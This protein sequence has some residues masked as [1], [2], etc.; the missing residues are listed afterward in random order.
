M[1]LMLHIHN[2]VQVNVD[3]KSLQMNECPEHGVV[4]NDACGESNIHHILR[5][6]LRQ[7]CRWQV[8]R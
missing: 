6:S 7:S 8:Q 1:I 4:I 2:R 5:R 3:V